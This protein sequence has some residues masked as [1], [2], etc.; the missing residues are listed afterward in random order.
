MS[1]IINTLELIDLL[2]S[3]G[4]NAVLVSDGFI[5]NI[6][7]SEKAVTLLE[8]GASFGYGDEYVIDDTSTIEVCGD[9]IHLREGGS[10]EAFP[11]QLL[12]I[13]PLCGDTQAEAYSLY[14]SRF[15]EADES[16]MT[17]CKQ[18]K[19]PVCLEEYVQSEECVND[20]KYLHDMSY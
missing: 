19:V 13:A 11:I 16:G 8:Y 14:V 15:F 10:G 20:M 7:V 17:P 18:G 5:F 2:E 12:S 9:T 1:T 4:A 3:K 6:Y